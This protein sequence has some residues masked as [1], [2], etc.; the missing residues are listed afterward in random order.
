MKLARRVIVAI[1]IFGA[2]FSGVLTY[3][4]LFGQ[5]ATVCPAPGQR[6]T[7]LGYPARVWGSFMYLAIVT[8]AILGLRAGRSRALRGGVPGAANRLHGPAPSARVAREASLLGRPQPL[9][10]TS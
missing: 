6:G 8:I 9:V 5:A 3:G 4:E 7:G 10:V 1:S 2:L